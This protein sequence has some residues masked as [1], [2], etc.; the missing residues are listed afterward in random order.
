LAS[1]IS[2]ALGWNICLAF[3]MGKIVLVQNKEILGNVVIK[4][5]SWLTLPTCDT[6]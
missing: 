6:L 2:N 5:E 4:E 1:A 3:V